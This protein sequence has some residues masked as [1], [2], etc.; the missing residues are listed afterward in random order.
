MKKVLNMA[1]IEDVKKAEKRLAFHSGTENV[2]DLMGPLRAAF[3]KQGMDL[4]VGSMEPADT[5]QR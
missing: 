1:K 2:F 4:P 5:M 3:Q